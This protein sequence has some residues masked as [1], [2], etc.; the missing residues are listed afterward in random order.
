MAA[1]KQRKPDEGLARSERDGAQARNELE[2][3]DVVGED[4]EAKAK[5]GCADDQVFKR[6]GDAFRALLAVHSAS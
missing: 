3:A 6:D 5:I 2:M 1:K 4:V